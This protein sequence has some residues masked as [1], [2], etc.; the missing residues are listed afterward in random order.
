MP[1][2]ST[3]TFQNEDGLLILHRWYEENSGYEEEPVLQYRL[4][5]S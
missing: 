5:G 3:I 2:G 4:S 1:D